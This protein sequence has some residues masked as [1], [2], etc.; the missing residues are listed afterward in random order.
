MTKLKLVRKLLLYPAL[1]LWP[2]MAMDTAASNSVSEYA[3]YRDITG[4]EVS[5]DQ[6]MA[7]PLEGEVYDVANHGYTDVRVFERE[8]GREIPRLIRPRQET[9]ETRVEKQH[10]AQIIDLI[11]QQNN[12]IQIIVKVPDNLSEIVGLRVATPLRNYE[13]SIS[14]SGAGGELLAADELLYDYSRFADVRQNKVYFAPGEYKS[15]TV[16][17]KAVT[18]KQA[19]RLMKLKE[20]FT[21]GVSTGRTETKT[22]ERRPFRID[23]ISVITRHVNRNT[24][25]YV[26]KRYQPEKLETTLD[27]EGNTVVDIH[28]L[29]QPLTALTVMTDQHNFSRPVIL[30]AI[31]ENRAKAADRRL[32]AKK[33]YDLNYGDIRERDMSLKFKETRNRKMRL[34]IKNGEYQPLAVNEV[35]LTGNIYEVLFLA[36]PGAQ[37]SVYYGKSAAEPAELDPSALQRLLQKDIEPITASLAGCFDNPAFK[38]ETSH[39]LNSNVLLMSVVVL[40]VLVLGGLLYG[41]TKKV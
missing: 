10:R 3:Y 23:A 33:I 21:G 9:S 27:K 37:Y 30:K 4:A 41:I 5:R 32:A 39:F 6:L 28:T 16:T 34:R 26:K 2:V 17:F 19:A 8:T 36:R 35:Q 15:L 22:I 11:K 31:S 18:D 1:I 40:M 12:R 7:V 38:P 25:S 24:V 14:V 20:T 13:R 29:R